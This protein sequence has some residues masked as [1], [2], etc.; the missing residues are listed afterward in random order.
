MQEKIQLA[1]VAEGCTDG[2]CDRVW[3]TT[4]PGI[5]GFQGQ[6]MDD[7]PGGVLSETEGITFF[8][9]AQALRWARRRLA[10]LGELPG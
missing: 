6:R 4:A 7:V 3:T 1:T 10:E 8:P 9:E 2:S 5:V